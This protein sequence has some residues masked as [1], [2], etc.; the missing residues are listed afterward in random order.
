MLYCGPQVEARMSKG[1]FTMNYDENGRITFQPLCHPYSGVS[2]QYYTR[3]QSGLCLRCA[4]CGQYA[5]LRVDLVC[6]NLRDSLE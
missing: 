3:N 6:L 1:R 5:R 4:E 2:I